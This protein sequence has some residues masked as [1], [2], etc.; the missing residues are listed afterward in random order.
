MNNKTYL[1]CTDHGVV[2]A[3]LALDD[4]DRIVDQLSEVGVQA[5][6]EEVPIN[7]LLVTH[8]AVCGAQALLRNGAAEVETVAYEHPITI[9]SAR[10]MAGIIEQDGRSIA[11][12]GFGVDGAVQCMLHRANIDAS[13]ATLVALQVAA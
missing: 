7:P 9:E 4:A 5:W 13:G 8:V 2:S 12:Y 6:I 10:A 1:L 11:G 3:Y